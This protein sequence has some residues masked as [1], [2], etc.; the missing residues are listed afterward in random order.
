MLATPPQP[1]KAVK[2]RRVKPVSQR[3]AY[4]SAG[5]T[6]NDSLFQACMNASGWS[7]Q[8]DLSQDAKAEIKERTDRVERSCAEPKYA[9]YYSK[10]AC[11]AD[12]ITITQ[13]ADTSTISPEAKAIF[14][15]LRSQ[16][17]SVNREYVDLLRKYSGLAGA[18]TATAY[19]ATITSTNQNNLAIYNGQ[20]T[21]GE[22]NKRRQQ[23]YREYQA[24]TTGRT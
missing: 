24:A 9:P 23:V 6:T 3:K 17:D 22:Y 14:L 10:T 4:A 18:K 7:L 11:A 20:I 2:K 5:Q 15:D 13:L 19:E 8:R 21:W 16:L 1:K 12:R